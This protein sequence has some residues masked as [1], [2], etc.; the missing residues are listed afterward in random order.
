[1]VWQ[2]CGREALSS[3]YLQAPAP[4]PQVSG[5][6]GNQASLPVQNRPPCP[7]ANQ[8]PPPPFPSEAAPACC[9]PYASLA[10]LIASLQP[11]RPQPL[12]RAKTVAFNYSAGLGPGMVRGGEEAGG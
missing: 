9:Q 4:S 8:S 5:V 6:E 1:M 10:E 11:C 3:A 2:R 12:S 7:S